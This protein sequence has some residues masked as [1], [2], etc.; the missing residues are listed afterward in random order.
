V[1]C[2]RKVIFYAPIFVR[3][4]NWMPGVPGCWPPD[5]GS[6]SRDITPGAVAGLDADD[7]RKRRLIKAQVERP[8]RRAFH[9]FAAL[10]GTALYDEI[11]C[12]TMV[13]R[14]FVLQNCAATVNADNPP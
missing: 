9:R 5:C 7:E 10:R 14:V 4:T 6:S 8:L 12:G 3:A 13:Y 2:D 1:S 11:R